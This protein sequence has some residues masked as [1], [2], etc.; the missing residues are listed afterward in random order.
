[1]SAAT[2]PP[3]LNDR[4]QFVQMAATATVLAAG[5]LLTSSE[6]SAS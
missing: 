2:S 6:F 5:A 4:Y 3:L 1:M